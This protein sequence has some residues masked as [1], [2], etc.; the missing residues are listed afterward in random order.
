MKNTILLLIA[1]L[2]F[3][4]FAIANYDEDSLQ[5]ETVKMIRFMDSVTSAMK[6]ET[7]SVK[8]SNGVAVLNIPKGF[9][10]LN[11]DQSKFVINKVWDNPERDDVLGMI[12]PE[13]GG[14]FADSSYAFIVSYDAIGYVKDE[15]ADEINYSNLLKE[16]Q[17]DEI[18]VNKE[19]LAKGYEAIH[20][21]GWAQQPFYDKQRKV[22][23]WAKELK[24][25]E[26]DV[27]TLN[28]DI[29]VLGRKGIL[30]FNAVAGIDGL[31][32]VKK[33][34]DK[35]LGMSNFTEG[36]KYEQF[37]SNLDEVAAYTIGGLVAGKILM[38]VGV[39]AM[40]AKF[41]KLIIGGLVAAWY[42]IKKFITGRK[43]KHEATLSEEPAVE[44][45]EKEVIV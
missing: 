17:N 35:V 23:H 14:P 3:S 41:W 6:Y 22:L 7:G 8:L 25:G 1:T 2:Y 33:D 27:N 29:R 34:I 4:N 30:S 45:P 44:V 19:R 9:K 39:W 36:N 31:P 24:F 37:D 40:I 28:Y 10:F 13:A 21:I 16:M 11:P 18:E 12:F 32:M 20:M 15:D 42:S 43:V 38:K 26:A 5:K